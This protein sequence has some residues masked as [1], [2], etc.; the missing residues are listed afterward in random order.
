[1]DAFNEF[2]DIFGLELK[3]EKSAIGTSNIFLG[4]SA[5]FP[6]PENSM[7][8]SLSLSPDKAAKWS[9]SILAIIEAQLISHA[10]LESLIGRLSFAQT[11][12]FGRFARAMLKP[13]Y[14][15]LYAPRFTSTISP[16]LA[17]NLSWRATTLKLPHPRVVKFSRS[18]PDWAI[19]TDAAFEDGPQGARLAA[20]FFE[21]P[22]TPIPFG[23]EL[24]LTSTPAP[25]EIAF[26]EATST[27][28]GLELS[29]VVLAIFHFRESLRDKAVTV[30]I[31]NN[32]ALAA[33]INGDSSSPA[34]YTLIATLWFVAATHNIALWFERVHT[35]NNIADLPT[36]AKSLP[37]PVKN[38]TDFPPLR[39]AIAHYRQHI[40]PHSHSLADWSLTNPSL[41]I[42]GTDARE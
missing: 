10:A 34:A 33:I 29:A 39:Q 41:P 17:R 6:S 16:A 5:Q 2:F 36:R 7:T 31:D 13:L 15:K 1:M 26:F 22:P 28:F 11:A 18:K 24:V 38:T 12:V 23:A 37:F 42:S 21:I 19:Y 40:A 25:G 8:L 4:L 20:I 3:R 27:I 14:A 9:D 30:Y 35:L 32:A